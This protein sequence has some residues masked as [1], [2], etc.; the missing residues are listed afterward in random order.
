MSFL[1]SP[2]ISQQHVCKYDEV[3][4]ELQLWN[5]EREF[6]SSQK[7]DQLELKKTHADEERDQQ[8]LPHSSSEAKSQEQEGSNHGD[9]GSTR[10]PENEKGKKGFEM[11]CY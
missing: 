8:L 1:I 9:S 4:P 7:D 3:M 10:N 2:G 11:D 5:Q 6:C